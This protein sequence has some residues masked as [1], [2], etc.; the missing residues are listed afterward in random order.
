MRAVTDKLAVTLGQDRYCMIIWHMS[1]HMG[2]RLKDSYCTYLFVL[3]SLQSSAIINLVL[4]L[5]DFKLMQV[6]I[7]NNGHNYGNMVPQ[8][9]TK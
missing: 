8:K 9:G 7:T 2:A 3:V 5:H 1:G 4:E 6:C